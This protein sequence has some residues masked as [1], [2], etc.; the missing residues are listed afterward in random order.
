MRDRVKGLLVPA[1]KNENVE[2]LLHTHFD[3]L[4]CA[5]RKPAIDVEFLAGC[6]HRLLRFFPCSGSGSSRRTPRRYRTG[7]QNTDSFYLRDLTS[8]FQAFAAFDDVQ[9]TSSP[10]GLRPQTSAFFSY[11]SG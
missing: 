6:E 1:L 9:L 7:Y 11:P 4:W 8:I 5:C 10:S 3:F 2:T